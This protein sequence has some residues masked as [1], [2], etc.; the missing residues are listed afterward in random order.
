[1]SFIIVDA[2]GFLFRAYHS[3]PPLTNPKGE[4]IG[5]IYGMLNMLVKLIND[6]NPKHIIMAL[7]SGRKTF[8]HDIFPQYKS[9]RPEPPDELKVQFGILKQMLEAMKL[10]FIA[11]DGVEAD[12]IIA[13]ITKKMAEVGEE[14]IVISS[15]KDLMQLLS[16]DKIKMY[17]AMKAK[18]ITSETVEAKFGIRPSEV[19]DYLALVGDASD[20]IPGAKGI[21][22]KTAQDLISR[23]HDLEGIYDNL[24]QLT[25]RQKQLME[26]SRENA[27]LSR[28]LISL[29]S[30]IEFDPSDIERY[31]FE[32]YNHR[33]FAIFLQQM[34]FHSVIKK[35]DLHHQLQ[36]TDGKGDEV[37]AHSKKRFYKK[38][39]SSEIDEKFIKQLYRD[40]EVFVF[41]EEGDV[42]ANFYLSTKNLCVQ[43][44]LECGINSSAQANL[45]GSVSD[46]ENFKDI[47]FKLSEIFQDPSIKIIT[48]DSRPIYTFLNKTLDIKIQNFDDLNVMSYLF[49]CGKF[50]HE[51]S[52]VLNHYGCEEFDSESVMHCY[53]T[54][55]QLLISQKLLGFYLEI[56]RKIPPLIYDIEDR[57]V[58]IDENA[59]SKLTAEFSKV[60]SEV[61]EKIYILA[62]EQF[63]IASPKQLGHILF[64]KLNIPS[65]KKSKTGSY[66]T[67]SEVLEKLEEQGYEI[68]RDV[69]QFRH[70]SK[71]LNTYTRALPKYL[72]DRDRRLHTQFQLTNTSTG[73]FSSQDPNLQN[74]PIRTKEGAKIRKAFSAQNNNEGERKVI[75][76]ADYSQIELRLLA[77]IADIKTMQN[78]INSGKDIHNATALELFGPDVAL[79]DKEIRRN[80]KAIN[81]GIIYGIS[82]FG[83]AKR[84]GITN[85]GA[86]EY[87]D[88]Y[89][90][91]FPGIKEYMDRTIDFCKTHGYVETLFGR[92]CYIPNI[93]NKNHT[94]RSF[95][96]RA[97]INAPLQGTAAD[98]MKKAMVYLPKEIKKYLVLQ[99]HDELLF[100]VPQ[101]IAKE[102]AG[103]I[104]R[105]MEGVVS[106][107]VKLETEV[108]YADNWYDT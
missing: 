45:L 25:P 106:F 67:N 75:L 30:D 73:R 58:Y 29:K 24:D 12:D 4:N 79:N 41:L 63:N 34:G 103:Q 77:H 89:F 61:E 26:E 60:L 1:M 93:N 90:L 72:N 14:S 98:I 74:I 102:L 7:D 68:C 54:M 84:L 78:A 82:P 44:Q 47:C 22:A 11:I 37:F 65:N 21:G 56:D 13:S 57:G 23:Y 100:E 32:G 16:D 104:K 19:L 108:K 5:A 27:F 50:K 36:N 2:Y 59:L 20:F 94:L 40:G 17:D 64:E 76:S 46:K 28:Q 42:F 105:T 10:N 43:F 39:S 69:L 92:K 18:F 31:E 88:T 81:F 51:G 55:Y 6:K 38:L 80:A 66:V 85:K 53:K 99:I 15:D 97:C 8:R 87:I 101:A 35:L 70:L 48:L 62:N 49:N 71:L 3:L 86:K 33:E 9:N 107:S 95:S 83:L 91:K 96:Q 52:A